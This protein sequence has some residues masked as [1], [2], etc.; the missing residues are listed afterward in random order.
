MTHSSNYASDRLALLL[1]QS[2]F[3]FVKQWTKLQLLT[4]SSVNLGNKFFEVFPEDKSPLW[5]VSRYYYYF[6]NQITSN[7]K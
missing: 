6:S 2:L 7:R 3:K 1:L 4:N 5:T